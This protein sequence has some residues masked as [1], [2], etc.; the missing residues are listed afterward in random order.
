MAEFLVTG[1]PE[2][3]SDPYVTDEYRQAVIYGRRCA[4]CG[5]TLNAESGALY[6]RKAHARKATEF[7]S[8]QR[9]MPVVVCPHP[10]KL[11]YNDRGTAL[12]SAAWHGKSFYQCDCAAFH[13]TSLPSDQSTQ[14]QITQL[15]RALYEEWTCDVMHERQSVFVFR[16]VLLQSDTTGLWTAQHPGA[17]WL[18]QSGSKDGALELLAERETK[19]LNREPNYL[20]WRPRALQ[21]YLN[22]G[23]LP[24]VY[25]VPF[26]ANVRILNHSDPSAALEAFIARRDSAPSDQQDSTELPA[27]TATA[28]R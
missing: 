4:W 27:E 24:G 7:R 13:L 26:E 25:E 17:S 1:S 3:E 23:P 10:E 12:R 15:R 16:P 11:A 20:G 22:E 14:R 9:S 5:K 21:H 28:E 6:C 19:M 18:V 8:R 2:P